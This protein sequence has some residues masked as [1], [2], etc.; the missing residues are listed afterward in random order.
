MMFGTIML[1]AQSEQTSFEKGFSITA[2]LY[3]GVNGYLFWSDN[4]FNAGGGVGMRYDF[5]RFWG[6]C[7]GLNYENIFKST[8][9]LYHYIIIPTEMEF[10]LKH[11]YVRGGL[12]VGSEVGQYT[13]GSSREFLIIGESLGLG[14]RINLTKSDLLTI[15]VRTSLYLGVI[16]VKD[17]SQFDISPASRANAA[18]VVGYEHKF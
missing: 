6:F 10:H 14:G 12:F 18:V 1:K 15:G 5:H 11:F 3:A 16:T 4:D 17:N 9:Y 2:N 7:T 13:N 8:S